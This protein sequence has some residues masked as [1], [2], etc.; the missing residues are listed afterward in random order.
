M[1]AKSILI[2]LDGLGDRS[3]ECLGFQTP[4]QAASTPALDRLARLGANGTYHASSPGKALPSERAHFNLFGYGAY[5]FPGRGP[6]EA[7]G[8]GIA[9]RP[10]DVAVLAHVVSVHEEDGHLVLDRGSP[11]ASPEEADE[12]TGSLGARSVGGIDIRFSRTKG[13]HGILTLHG[14]VAPHITDSD[15]M[16]EGAPLPEIL[17]WKE[18][19]SGTAAAATAAAL[20]KYLLQAY[21]LLQ[22]HPVNAKRTARGLPPLNALATQ[23]AGCL[24]GVPPFRDLFNLRALSLASGFVYKGLSTYLGMDFISVPDTGDPG[25]DIAGRISRAYN[26]LADYDF[27]HVHT[28]APDEAAHSKDPAAKKA[29]IETLDRGIARAI[30]PLTENRDVLWTVTADHSTPSS[31]PLVHSGEPVPLLLCGRG[32][33][34]DGITRFDEISA[35]GGS[36]GCVRGGELIDL[37]LNYLDLARLQGIMDTPEERPFWPGRYRPFRL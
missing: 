6:L 7:L 5:R 11:P 34:R 3:H 25:R 20:K 8:A 37:I 16:R 17:P 27:I 13:L 1:P 2:I 26:A 24:E 19:G 14:N 12:I 28:K 22:K 35:A 4:L 33:R 32:V 36:L 15:P 18:H 31:G 30:D 9:L 10:G 21:G 23:R 29:V